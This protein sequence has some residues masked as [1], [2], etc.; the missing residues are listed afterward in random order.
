MTALN[1][2]LLLGIA[3]VTLAA[4]GSSSRS[5]SPTPAPGTFDLRVF[6]ASP[7]APLVNILVNGEVLLDAVDYAQSSG[8]FTGEAGSFDIAVEAITPGGNAIVIDVAGVPLEADLQYS[9]LAVGRVASGGVIPP[10]QELVVAVPR[11]SIGAGN[12][13]ATIVHASP[14]APAVDVYVT[15]PEAVIGDGSTQPLDSIAFSEVI[16][17]AELP[18][19][20]A[21]VR[22]TPANDAHT[23]L[24]DSGELAL[25]AGADLF[26]AAI[27]NTVGGQAVSPVKLLINDGAGSSV[28]LDAG[29]TADVR[30]VH[31][32]PDAPAVDVIVDD[33]FETPLVSGLEF[34]DFTPYVG[35]APGDYNI[36]VV[37]NASQSLTA[38]E[39]EPSLEAGVFYTVIAAGLL[40]EVGF[41]ENDGIAEL[42]LVDDNRRIA[43]EARVR[44]VHGSTAAG[45][46]D[47]YVLPGGTPLEGASPAFAGVE[48]RQ[49]TGY[50]SLEPGFWDVFVT[51]AGQPGVVAIA[52]PGLIFSP[53]GIYTA[54]ARDAQNLVGALGLILIDDTP[55]D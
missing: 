3:A 29:T 35:V 12:L 14:D 48:F 11:A 22:I 42:V 31:N 40:D 7:D 52:A 27:T 36:K 8:F 18:A 28:V 53:L 54:I 10:L 49:Q 37:D 25:P 5:S 23:I 15:A 38:I 34:P 2:A 33:A 44:I 4:C 46:V 1:R 19:G 50:V 26:I 17:P 47:I 24:F 30:V 51:P 6:H 32:S 55:G 16:G 20:P 21:R 39:F 41:P 13:R 9:V 43:T 45:P